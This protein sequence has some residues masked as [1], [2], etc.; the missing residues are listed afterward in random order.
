MIPGLHRWGLE[1]SE[2]I[3]RLERLAPNLYERAQPPSLRGM[4]RYKS[5]TAMNVLLIHP[6]VQ[7]FYDADVR[8]Q[9]IGRAYLKAAVKKHLPSIEVVI[10]D[11]PGG[12]GRRTVPIPPEL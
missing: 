11:Y 6:P 2:A 12:C 8:L 7:D 3:E 10:K 9:P 1:L 5:S 4:M